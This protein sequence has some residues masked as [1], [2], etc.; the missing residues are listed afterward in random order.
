[1]ADSG[2][3][4][5]GVSSHSSFASNDPT[6]DSYDALRDCV[7]RRTRSV[8]RPKTA[9]PRR[10]SSEVR[11]PSPPMIPTPLSHD[12]YEDNIQH[13]EEKDTI[14][15]QDVDSEPETERDEDVPPPMGSHSRQSSS[16]EENPQFVDR[17]ESPPLQDLSFVDRHPVVESR[18]EYAVEPTV[19]G[20]G[21]GN[22][23]VAIKGEVASFHVTCRLMNGD[24]WEWEVRHLHVNVNS[25]LASSEHCLRVA[26]L[27]QQQN[28]YPF[29]LKWMI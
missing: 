4:Y 29:S 16:R 12:D 14:H 6:F 9:Y 19:S 18:Q 25:S 8:E 11:P 24:P 2:A 28:L 15:V 21:V 13:A 20:P 1:M 5:T 3:N 10:R 17:T 27:P 7:T 23:G 26:S 22:F